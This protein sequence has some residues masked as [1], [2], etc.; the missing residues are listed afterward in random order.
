MLT[1]HFSSGPSYFSGRNQELVL[2]AGKSTFN[3]CSIPRYYLLICN[4]AGDIHIWDQE[5]GEL[6]R[7]I[8]SNASGGDLTCIAW[9]P[10]SDENFMFATGGH[11]GLVRIWTKPSD[12]QSID[13]PMITR[14]PSPMEIILNRTESPIPEQDLHAALMRSASLRPPDDPMRGTPISSD[15]QPPPARD[16][17]SVA[18]VTQGPAEDQFYDAQ[19]DPN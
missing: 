8:G 17:R 14:S 13:T 4:E 19:Q 11:D 9:N 12:F 1:R 18:F 5:S 15:L 6:L 7:H 16:Q 2:C 10:T 3:F